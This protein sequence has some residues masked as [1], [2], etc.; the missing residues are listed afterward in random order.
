MNLKDF[1]LSSTTLSQLVNT[2][3]RP[4]QFY[5]KDKSGKYLE[6]NDGSARNAGFSN[7]EEMRGLSDFDLE[8]LP[9]EQVVAWHA[10]DRKVI[11]QE[12]LQLFDEAV[13]LFD[14]T[15]VRALSHKMPFYS[16]AKKIIGSAGISIIVDKDQDYSSAIF[17]ENNAIANA[18]LLVDAHLSSREIECLFYLIK[19]QSAKI[20]ANNLSISQRTVEQHLINCKAK[21]NC[22]NRYE[23]IEKAFQITVIKE[24]LKK[25]LA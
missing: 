13:T 24:L 23:L 16:S 8:F 1:H 6:A 5:I 25:D 15:R 17:N 18:P 2:A 3:A 19:G 20:M 14:G 10:N 9:Y 21:L 12:K 4:I 7:A 22:V 11:Y